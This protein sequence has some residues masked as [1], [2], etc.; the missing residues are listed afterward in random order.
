MK[1]QRDALYLD[2]VE[3]VTLAIGAI[4]VGTVIALINMS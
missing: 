3:Y 2:W 4:I 1:R